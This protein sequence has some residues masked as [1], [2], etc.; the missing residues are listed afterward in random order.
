MCKKKAKMRKRNFLRTETELFKVPKSRLII[1]LLAGLFFAFCFYA[2]MY[3]TRESFR[4]VS[5]TKDYDLWILTDN[6][7]GFYNLFFAF[8]S[9]IFAQSICFSFWFDK[10]LNI[11][12]R[13]RFQRILIGNDQSALNTY[14]LFWFSELAVIYGLT[15]GSTFIGGFYVFSFYPK[16]NYIFVLI[17]IV[18]FLQTWISIR[19]INKKQS[20][21][22]MFI[23]IIVVSIIAIGLS[24]INFVDYKGVNNIALQKNIPYQYGL[25]LPE[26]NCAVSKIENRSLSMDIYVVKNKQQEDSTPKIFIDNQEV[27]LKSLGA[28]IIEFQSAKYENEVNMCIYHLYIDKKIKMKFINELKKEMANV[29]AFKIAFAFVPPNAQYDKRYYRDYMLKFR[30]PKYDIDNNTLVDSYSQLVD[31]ENV[32]EIENADT[33]EFLINGKTYTVTE[34]KQ[35]IKE[36]IINNPNY[37]V[38]YYINDKVDF[39]VYFNLISKTKE[40]VDEL[41]NEYALKNYST[42]FESLDEEK[43]DKTIEKIGFHIFELTN[44]MKKQLE[45]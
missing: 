9:V 44:E 16:Y 30:I 19:R 7:V 34:L 1:G 12:Y 43:M 38:K 15:F 6:E 40:V 3:L 4:L 11:F 45:N 13:R 17:I 35:T 32:I 31:I 36:R 22:W 24:K 20:L 8:I 10:P 29:G 23:S 5:L 37:T 27:N 33:G 21:K 18:L 26:S 28:K 25:E 42:D 2:F 41:R 39:L 14:F